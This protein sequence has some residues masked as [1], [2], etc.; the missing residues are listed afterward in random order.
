MA[1]GAGC[2]M[3]TRLQCLWENF[4]RDNPAAYPLWKSDPSAFRTWAEAHGYNDGKLLLRY[5]KKRGYIPENCHWSD[6]KNRGQG[7]GAKHYI[8]LDGEIR[9]VAEWSRI[10]G[11]PYETIRGRLCSGKAPEEILR[12]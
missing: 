3:S 11:I 4:I 12:T 7:R 5:H 8:T 1:T 6:K 2:T 9:S 10:T